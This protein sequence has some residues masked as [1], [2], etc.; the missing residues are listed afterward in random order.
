MKNNFPSN[1]ALQSATDAFEITPGPDDL[2][3]VP[4]A[5]WIGAGGN[6]VVE[7]ISG[8]FTF[9]NVPGGTFLLVRPLKVLATTTASSIL[10]LV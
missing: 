8:E 6:V 10:G 3:E 7:L 1:N 2:Q 5:L 9:A 4:R